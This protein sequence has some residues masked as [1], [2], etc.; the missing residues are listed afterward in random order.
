MARKMSLNDSSQD[1]RIAGGEDPTR[2]EKAGCR[3]TA[4]LLATATI[5]IVIF[6]G[7]FVV[8]INL[9]LS[10][11]W[12]FFPGNAAIVGIVLVRYFKK[13]LREPYFKLFLAAW[14]VV[15]GG[16][17]VFLSRMSVPFAM[18]PVFF[19]L[20]LFLGYLFAYFIFGVRREQGRDSQ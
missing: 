18:W 5:V 11:M 7:A 13:Y 3:D 12:V 14:A 15:H 10:P 2:P 1:C 4:L 9:N 17:T 8:T 6:G 20:E 19:F 16:L